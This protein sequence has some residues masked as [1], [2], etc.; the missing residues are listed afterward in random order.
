MANKWWILAILL[1]AM[2]AWLGAEEGWTPVP[3]NGPSP[4]KGHSMAEINGKVYIF[5]GLSEARADLLNDLWVFEL[6]NEQW[7]Q[8]T[9]QGQLPLPRYGHKATVV[10]NK[11]FIFSGMTGNAE[12][13]DAWYYDPQSNSWS[14]V[15]PENNWPTPRTDYSMV[16]INNY[17]YVFGGTTFNGTTVLNDMHSYSLDSNRWYRKT[18]S[19][20][21]TPRFGHYAGVVGGKMYVIGGSNGEELYSNILVYDPVSNTWLTIDFNRA[22]PAPLYYMSG[23]TDGE[24]IWIAGGRDSQ[25]ND[26][27]ATWKYDV[28]QNTWVQQSDGPIHAYGASVPVIDNN[29]KVS[30]FLFG[31][32]RNGQLLG[33]TW[34]YV[35]G[36][37]QPLQNEL[38]NQIGALGRGRFVLY[39]LSFPESQ[40]LVKVELGWGEDQAKLHLL[41]ANVSCSARGKSHP[42]LHLRGQWQNFGAKHLRYLQEVKAKP[43]SL[44]GR[45]VLQ[46]EFPT[47]RKGL[48]VLLVYHWYFSK[49][50]REVS[51]KIT[52][53]EVLPKKVSMV[54]PVGDPDNK[55]I[56]H[57]NFVRLPQEATWN[58]WY[59]PN[60]LIDQQI[61]PGSGYWQWNFYD[62]NSRLK[63]L[64]AWVEFSLP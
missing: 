37:P 10:N 12:A 40:E 23:M 28:A 4:R 59:P 16:A 25:S 64:P 54:F 13:A 1:L 3:A 26:L 55:G 6:A 61:T 32:E 31:G 60:T 39:T 14:P 20:T 17:I 29:R 63:L 38:V 46:A 27:A 51:L 2:P 52:D 33:E 57:H 36:D 7:T 22:A 50:A 9:P 44:R 43:L 41:A 19:A 47:V 8:I 48:L 24:S 21:T 11:M 58:S 30:M 18:A 56:E 62:R 49:A 34:T 15:V 5:G 35:A 45:K 53:L 42:L